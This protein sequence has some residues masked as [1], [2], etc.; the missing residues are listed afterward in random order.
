MTTQDSLDHISKVSERMVQVIEDLTR[1][2]AVHDASKLE[3]PELSGYEKLH[4][5]LTPIAYGTPEYKATMAKFRWLIDHHFAANDHH[6]EHHRNG[7]AGMT[8]MSLVEMLC[9]WKAAS[10]RPTSR[11]AFSLNWN[12][13][14]FGIEPQLAAILRNTARELGWLPVSGATKRYWVSWEQNA[15]D[16]EKGVRR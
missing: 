3:E 11:S 16:D 10:E 7:V 9:D 6:P 15:V 5:E 2:A 1:R 12:V 8:L 13:D 14:R 4:E